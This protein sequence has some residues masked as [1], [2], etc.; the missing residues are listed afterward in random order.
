MPTRRNP[1]Y[2]P[3]NPLFRVSPKQAQPLKSLAHHP[4]KSVQKCALVFSFPPSLNDHTIHFTNSTNTP[5]DSQVVDYNN[6]GTVD[7]TDILKGCN[8]LVNCCSSFT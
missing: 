4:L 7:D 3:N 5:L 1:Q 2:Q 6:D 8:R